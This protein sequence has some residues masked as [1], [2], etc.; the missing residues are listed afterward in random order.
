MTGTILTVQHYSVHDGPG[1]RTLVFMKGCPMHCPWCCNPE[2]QTAQPQL[3][4]IR[5]RCKACLECVI[6]C[7]TSSISY[8][9]KI[10]H[11]SF[12]ICNQCQSKV[13]IETCNYDAVSLSGKNITSDELADIIA[14]DIPFYRNSGGGVT[15]SGGEPLMQPAFLADVL[16]KCKELKIHTAI[17]TCGWA[18]KKT[19]KDIIPFTDLFLFDLKIIDP[20]LHMTYTGKPVGPILDNLAYLASQ[21]TETV[22]RV[23]LIPGITDT[24]QNLEHITEIMMKNNLKR[25]CLE[26]Y[27]SL[28]NEKYEEHGMVYRPDYLSHYDPK[29][30]DALCYFFQG[31]GFQCEVVK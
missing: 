23:P 5:S 27:H 28:G 3:R 21:E 26:P 8:T 9:E 24:L 1:I 22:I 29:Q 30:V 13:C 16:E 4:Y 2:S 20:G 31:K 15:F 19:I 11:R 7:P 6:H 10:I 17:E 14:L 18:D 12:D 25:I